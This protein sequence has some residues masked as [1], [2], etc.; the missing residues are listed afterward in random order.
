IFGDSTEHV[1]SEITAPMVSAE[2]AS[3]RFSLEGMLTDGYTIVHP[4]AYAVNKFA[5][6]L[7]FFILPSNY[8]YNGY[9]VC[10]NYI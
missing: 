9:L 4:A 8:G 5:F 7:A 1:K 2:N 3:Q 6:Q 10:S